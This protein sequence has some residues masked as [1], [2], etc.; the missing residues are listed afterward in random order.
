MHYCLQ[1]QRQEVSKLVSYSRLIYGGWMTQALFLMYTEID[2]DR[3]VNSQNE[4]RMV[5]GRGGEGSLY[6]EAVW[7]LFI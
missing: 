1:I 6:L 2:L 4:F 5:L 3:E 7:E